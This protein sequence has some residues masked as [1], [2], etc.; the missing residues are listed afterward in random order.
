MSHYD[1]SETVKGIRNVQQGKDEE[2][3]V[4]RRNA[5]HG[6]R[7]EMFRRLEGVAWK[8][9]E[10]DGTESKGLDEGEERV[11]PM[12]K[13]WVYIG[14]HGRWRKNKAHKTL[15]TEHSLIL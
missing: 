10:G 8:E 7:E 13:F 6:L 1:G 5:G 4:S 2:N 3:S 14:D 11:F 15:S 9:R 12:G